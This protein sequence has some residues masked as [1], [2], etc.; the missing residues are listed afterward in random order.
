MLNGLGARGAL[1]GPYYAERLAAHLCAG[2]E[3]APQVDVARFRD[4]AE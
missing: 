2:E 4:R 3:L 1:L